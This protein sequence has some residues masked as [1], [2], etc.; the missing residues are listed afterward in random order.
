MKNQVIILGL[1]LFCFT[2]AF[3]QNKWYP[4]HPQIF[5]NYKTGDFYRQPFTGGITA[6]QFAVMDANF[7]GRKDLIVYDRVG[8][9]LSVFADTAK[10]GSPLWTYDAYL[11]ALFPPIQNWFRMVDYDRDGDL[12]IFTN[13]YSDIIVYDNK[14]SNNKLNFTKKPDSLYSFLDST[15]FGFPNINMPCFTITLPEVNDI[16]NDGDYDIIV[17]DLSGGY[18]TM[19]Q[20]VQVERKLP[21]DSLMYIYADDCYGG[22]YLPTGDNKVGLGISCNK[23]YERHAHAGTCI[24]T[25]DFDNDGDKDMLLGDAFLSEVLY[26]KNGKKEFNWAYDSAIAQDT[27][28]LPNE[29]GGASSYSFAASFI[30]DVDADGVVDL[31]VASNDE[32]VNRDIYNIQ[33]FKNT[34]TNQLPVFKFVTQSFLQ[35]QTIDEGYQNHPVFFD[36]DGDSLLDLVVGTGGDKLQNQDTV[37]VLKL[38]KNIGTKYQPI[39]ILTDSNWLNLRSKKV[40]WPHA[41]FGDVD[42]DQLPDM[43]VG[44]AS[45]K[46]LY[47]KNTGTSAA[48]AFTYQYDTFAGINIKVP[49]SPALGDLDK[50]GDM[51]LMLGKFNGELNYYTNTSGNYVL[52]T[53]T[54]GNIN[55]S[56]SFYDNVDEQWKMMHN[57]IAVPL[58]YDINADGNLDLMVGSF[59]GSLRLYMD[60]YKYVNTVAIETDSFQYSFIK[61]TFL[62]VSY[63]VQVSPAIGFLDGDSLPDILLGTQRGGMHFWGSQKVAQ[64]KSSGFSL[65]PE[66]LPFDV[67]P[68][69]T[70]SVLYIKLPDVHGSFQVSVNDITGKLAVSNNQKH[71]GGS[72][73]SIDIKDFPEGIYIVK[74][75]N[76]KGVTGYKKVVKN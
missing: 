20:N 64:F 28:Y 68:N 15:I 57:G 8:A 14:S 46:I 1:M 6:P 27:I 11:S 62:N 29:G 23:F 72:Y 54:F 65:L 42:G 47:W 26:V 12:D 50:D 53:D 32:K 21:K 3:S 18:L 76:E 43:L 22:F 75:E 19:Y 30:Q 41:T 34:G 49:V 52:T 61:D 37:S 2:S 63:K 17:T 73:I 4:T 69:P 56:D 67:F 5:K 44:C 38:Y 74:I 58:L 48:P 70:S 7:D 25:Y 9:K 39:Y 13:Q 51:D 10:S 16:D 71:L 60:A 24:T 55:V 45:G 66:Y 59:K 40:I 33:F 31:L 35:E 36:V